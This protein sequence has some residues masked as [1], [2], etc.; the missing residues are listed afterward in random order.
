MKLGICFITVSPSIGADSEVQIRELAEWVLE[1]MELFR[2]ASKLRFRSRALQVGIAFETSRELH[3][4]D[5]CDFAVL[6]RQ[7]GQVLLD[8]GVEGVLGVL[9]QLGTKGDEPRVL[10]ALGEEPDIAEFIDKKLLKLLIELIRSDRDCR[11][12]CNR[13]SFGSPARRLRGRL[14]SSSCDL[15]L[16]QETE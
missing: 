13:P 1:L 10:D 14:E 3:H 16:T 12:L 4:G 5:G 2:G 8:L 11:P 9:V 7:R 6:R 15:G